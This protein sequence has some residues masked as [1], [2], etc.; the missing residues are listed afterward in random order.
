[1]AGK[2]SNDWWI[3]PLLAV[4]CAVFPPLYIVV[5]LVALFNK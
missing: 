3:L 2:P 1:M 4:I 5:I